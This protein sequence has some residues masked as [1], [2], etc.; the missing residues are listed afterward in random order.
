[1]KVR[2]RIAGPV[3]PNLGWNPKQLAEQLDVAKRVD[4]LGEIAP[5]ARASELARATLFVLPS[6]DESFGVAAAESMAAACPTLLSNNVGIAQAAHAYGACELIDDLSADQL[7]VRISELIRSTRRLQ[8]IG[9][10]GTD[11]AQ[12]RFSWSAVASEYA[13]LYRDLTGA[14]TSGPRT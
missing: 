4:F 12:T 7:S 6:E 13:S 14:H 3:D 8:E 10:G 5:T 9:R 11:F 1:M 2:L